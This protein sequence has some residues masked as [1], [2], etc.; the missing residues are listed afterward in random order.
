MRLAGDLS[1][2]KKLKKLVLEGENLIENKLKLP[3]NLEELHCSETK[4]ILAITGNLADCTKLKKLSL[5]GCDL[6]GCGLSR[7]SESVEE[8]DLSF[9]YNMSRFMT[10]LTAYKNLK[11]VTFNGT[12][13]AVGDLKL[14]EGCA[15][16]INGRAAVGAMSGIETAEAVRMDKVVKAGRS[17]K[18]APERSKVLRGMIAGKRAMMSRNRA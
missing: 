17:E 10:D 15:A 1:G 14:P 11:K 16:V 12:D 13:F 8:L 4:G 7:L 18:A 5:I 6:K 2:Q 3:E 9:S